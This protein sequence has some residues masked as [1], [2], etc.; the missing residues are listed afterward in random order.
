M[1]GDEPYRTLLELAH[2]PGLE[3]QRTRLLQLAERQAANDCGRALAPGEVFRWEQDCVGAPN[4][5]DDLFRVALRRLEVLK[6]ERR[7]G[8]LQ[9]PRTVQF[10][11]RRTGPPE[12]PGKSP[13]DRRAR[14]IQRSSRR[15]GRPTESHGHTLVAF[16]GSGRDYRGEVRQQMD[17]CGTTRFAGE[18]ACRK[19]SARPEFPPRHPAARPFG[20]EALL[21]D[22]GPQ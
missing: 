15:R 1:P 8:R 19:V 18:P 12:I 14:S 2:M 21:A 22:A 3:D 11:H 4:T 10:G 17:L 5:S 7:A 20:R 13:E 9:R 6:R 16:Q